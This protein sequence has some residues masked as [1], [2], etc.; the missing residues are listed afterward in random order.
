MSMNL[1]VKFKDM[2]KHRLNTKTRFSTR[3]WKV[4]VLYGYNTLGSLKKAVV[5]AHCD[6]KWKMGSLCSIGRSQLLREINEEIERVT[7]KQI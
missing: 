1:I 6:A 5:Q 4:G 2:T 3:L 7:K